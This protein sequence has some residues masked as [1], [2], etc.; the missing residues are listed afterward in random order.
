MQKED[1]AILS[2]IPYFGDKDDAFINEI[3]EM[4]SDSLVG[5]EDLPG[6]ACWWPADR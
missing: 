5:A 3:G 4:F 1:Q 2:H 6:V